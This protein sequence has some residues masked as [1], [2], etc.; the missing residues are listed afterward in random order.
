VAAPPDHTRVSGEGADP[1]SVI[2][3]YV[4]HTHPD[5]EEW[6]AKLAGA[7]H[8]PTPMGCCGFDVLATATGRIYG[9]TYGTGGFALRDLERTHGHVDTARFEALPDLGPGWWIVHPWDAATPDAALVKRLGYF[10]R[11]AHAVAAG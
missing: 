6:V 5:L 9:V 4:R 2:D 8:V 10:V 7:A 3:G 1:G 11:E